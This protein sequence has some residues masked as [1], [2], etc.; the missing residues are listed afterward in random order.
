MRKIVGLAAAF[1][2]AASAPALADSKSAAEFALKTCLAAMD[3]LATVEAIARGH[4]WT[5]KSIADARGMK[6]QSMWEGVQGEDRF[7]VMIGTMAVE[8]IPPLNMCSVFFPG[9]NLN[10][11]EFFNLISASVE[12]TF[13]R[14]NTRPQSRIETYEIKSDRTN[15]L[16]LNIMSQSDGTLMGTMMQEM[17][18]FAPRPTAPV[19]PGES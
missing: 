4:N 10:R 6:S 14:E 1:A 3:D 8:K 18:R 11:D 2:L 7:I 15:K 5:A 19:A 13:L 12:L 16:M 9:R 17:P